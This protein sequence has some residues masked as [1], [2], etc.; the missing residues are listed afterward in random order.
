MLVNRWIVI[1]YDCPFLKM[2]IF[3]WS[4]AHIKGKLEEERKPWTSNT[5]DRDVEKS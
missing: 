2:N 4:Q 5:K 1:Q 3:T